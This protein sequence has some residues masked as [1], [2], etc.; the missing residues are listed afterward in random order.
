VSI[1]LN[2]AEYLYMI[3]CIKIAVW[4]NFVIS[5]LFAFVSTLYNDLLSV[6]YCI[7]R[8]IQGKINFSLKSIISQT[9]YPSKYLYHVHN[10]KPMAYHCQL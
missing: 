1:R 2:D 9:F 6:L 7:Y 3:F 8:K 10:H 4:I 5:P